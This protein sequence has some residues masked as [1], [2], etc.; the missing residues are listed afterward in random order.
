MAPSEEQVSAAEQ[1]AGVVNKLETAVELI[2]GT[3]TRFKV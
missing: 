2:N 1:L 3:L